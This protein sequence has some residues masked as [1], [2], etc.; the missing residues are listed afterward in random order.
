M[1]NGLWQTTAV[2]VATVAVLGSTAYA[3]LLGC[4]SSAPPPRQPPPPAWR[5]VSEGQIATPGVQI[6]ADGGPMFRLVSGEPFRRPFQSSCLAFRKT[7]RVDLWKH[8]LRSGARRVVVTIEGRDRPLYGVLAFCRVPSTDSSAASRSYRMLL[9]PKIVAQT[10]GQR[11]VLLGEVSPDVAA[12]RRHNRAST[13]LRRAKLEAASAD[14]RAMVAGFADPALRGY[15]VGNATW[16]LWLSE[17][18]L[19]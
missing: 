2:A 7:P 16:M 4:G 5:Q 3:V 14:Q 17:T 15:V 18:P 8:A 10:S 6:D 1:M 9:D 12:A 13:G 11:M 19:P